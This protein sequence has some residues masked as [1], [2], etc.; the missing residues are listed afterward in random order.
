M[1]YTTII[2]ITE[3]PTL[4][5]NQATRLVYL[6]LCL[7]SGYHDYDRDVSTLSIRKIA[8]DTGLTVA[9]VRN[10]LDQLA[11]FQ[12]IKRNGQLTK[13]RKFIIEQPISKRAKTA[14]Q[15][16]AEKVTEQRKEIERQQ[17]EERRHRQA[18]VD[19]LRSEGKTSFMVYYEEQ[20]QKAA[21]GDVAA[22]EFCELQKKVYSMHKQSIEKDK[23]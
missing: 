1:R 6:H 5:K 13:V 12:M 10:A 22:A 23:K 14:K 2:D 21:A 8:F 17:Q 7:R 15:A 4:Y 20:L 11:K 3:F 18:E 16:A 9:A 19:K